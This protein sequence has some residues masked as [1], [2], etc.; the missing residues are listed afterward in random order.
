M[1]G[2]SARSES[3]QDNSLVKFAR[4]RTKTSR[5]LSFSLVF[6]DTSPWKLSR[7]VAYLDFTNFCVHLLPYLGSRRA[8]HLVHAA[9]RP[10]SSPSRLCIWIV[11][12]FF[13]LPRIEKSPLTILPTL[14]FNTLL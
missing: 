9:S 11:H 14:S 5:K 8:G 6:R 7:C 12:I 13:Q 10:Q 3:T 4:F 1:V 2:L